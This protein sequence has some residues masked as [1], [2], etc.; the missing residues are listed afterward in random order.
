MIQKTAFL[1]LTLSL[2]LAVVSAGSAAGQCILANPSFE[3]GGQAGAVFGGWNQFGAI[4]A[5]TGAYHG[6]QAARVSGSNTGSWELSA[7]WQ[8]QDCAPG[9]SWAITGHVKH[10]AGNPLTGQC[11]AIVNVEWRDSGGALIDYDTFTV[12]DPASPTDQYLDFAVVSSAAPAGTVTA[13]ILVG[14][15]QSPTDPSPDVFYDQITF[16]ST[17]YPTSDDRQWNDFPGGRTLTFGGRTWRIK[18]PGY[19]GPGPNL[20]SD[21]ADFVW[22]DGSDQLHLTLQQRGANWYC[23][24]VVTEEALGYGDYV[25]TTVGRL[26]QIDPQ[27]VLGIFL[28]EYGPCYDPALVWWNPYNEIDIEYSRWGNPAADIGQFVAQPYDWNGNL[29]RF[30]HAFGEGQVTS[31]A[32]RW[33][34]DKVEYRVWRGGPGDESPANLIHSWTYTGPHIPRPEQ[35]RMHLNLWRAGSSPAGDQEV[36]FKDFVF[37]PAG[38]VSAVDEKPDGTAPSAGIGR[39]YPASPNP[40]NPRTTIGYSLVR[41]GA[42]TLDV[43][44]LNGRRVRTLADGFQTAGDHRATWDGLDDGGRQLASG[45]YLVRLRGDGFLEL[46]RV[47][48][49]K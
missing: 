17:S 37:V 7:F 23:T 31:H 8:S 22:V 35:P 33:L 46:Q 14:V 44:D 47:A 48:L 15:L 30:D 36:V 39:L 5:V 12:A 1:V 25:L 13:R 19:F 2:S 40:F 16:D 4:G 28:W 6:A 21:A 27:V 34:A 45:V 20:F 29:D 49:I 11:A 42:V 43:Y 3:I 9:E 10:P 24:E 26:D 41:D 32:M 18:G 38:T